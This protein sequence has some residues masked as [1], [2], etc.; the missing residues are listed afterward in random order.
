MSEHTDSQ[1]ETIAKAATHIDPEA[2][3][4]ALQAATTDLI[5]SWRVELGLDEERPGW[6][7][8]EDELEK[9]RM[10][11]KVEGGQS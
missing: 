3:P 11:R 9:A 8:P 4:P 6:L 5:R 2:M 7:S 1:F 10:M